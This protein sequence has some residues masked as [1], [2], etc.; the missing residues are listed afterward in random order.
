MQGL[1][2]S[3][4][5]V[6]QSALFSTARHVSA[7]LSQARLRR[8][9]PDK[10]R[11]RK[12]YSVAITSTNEI[13]MES[14]RIRIQGDAPLILQA[15]TLAD[16]LHPLTLRYKETT[17]KQKK[18]DTDQRIMGD[19]EF[20]AGLYYDEKMGPYVPGEVVAKCLVEAARLSKAGKQ[21]ERGVMIQEQ[22]IEL[23]YDGPRDF[24]SL[25]ND[26]KYHYRKTVVVG[27]ARTVRV[28][29]I[30]HEWALECGFNFMED[31]VDARAIAGA[32]ETAGKLIG[33]GQRRP[34][35]GG[36]FGRFNVEVI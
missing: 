8:A 26:W 6:Q 5:H 27:K 11:Q 16:P 36:Q 34:N 20:E 7:L 25:L 24:K 23:L 10:A 9:R 32:M 14:I 1:H 12:G 18:T 31:V 15:D 19:I 35:K 29:P 30:F 13:I 21:M 3:E 4:Q 28:R 33:I 22:K 2:R 17:R